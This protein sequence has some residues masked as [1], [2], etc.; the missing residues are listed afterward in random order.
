MIY[1]S[2]LPTV[3]DA[4]VVREPPITVDSVSG[5]TDWPPLPSLSLW[6][7]VQLLQNGHNS[8]ATPLGDI[9]LALWASFQ[10]HYPIFVGIPWCT[11]W[12]NGIISLVWGSGKKEKYT[13]GEDVLI[14][15]RGGI[16]VAARSGSSKVKDCFLQQMH[17]IGCVRPSWIQV[18]I[19]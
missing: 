18:C 15:W 4:H 19:W 17:W 10:R 16:M 9:P 6:I 11:E 5:S 3:D 1:L 13:G 14:C 12:G 8:Q 7:L 2:L